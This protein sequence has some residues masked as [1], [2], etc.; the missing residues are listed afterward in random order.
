M[1]LRIWKKMKNKILE[2]IK[3]RD[4]SYISETEKAL[5]IFL[6]DL[7]KSMQRVLFDS[8]PIELFIT[9]IG[10]LPQNFR[11]CKLEGKIAKKEIGDKLMESVDSDAE[12]N[13]DN[14]WD[15]AE[16]FTLIIPFSLLDEPVVDTLDEY[17]TKVKENEGKIPESTLDNKNDNEETKEFFNA[18]K[19]LD[20]TQKLDI[21]YI[22][23]SSV[24]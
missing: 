12:V 17:F 4:K 22:K 13:L 18:K 24:H 2:I 9:D 11:F 5:E 20:S 8:K 1:H 14:F 23:N 7:K 15:V 3:N 6:L 19:E 21:K 16:P 10:I